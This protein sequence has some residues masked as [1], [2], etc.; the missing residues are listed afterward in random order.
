MSIVWGAEICLAKKS[1]DI[2]RKSKAPESAQRPV[3]MPVKLVPG[4]G[5]EPTHP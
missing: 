3:F 2:G 4:A 1:V 5:I